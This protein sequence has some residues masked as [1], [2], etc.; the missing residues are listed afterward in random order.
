M[1]IYEPHITPEE[2]YERLVV[3]FPHETDYTIKKMIDVIQR[4]KEALPND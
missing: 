4:L 3:R 1:C 2:A